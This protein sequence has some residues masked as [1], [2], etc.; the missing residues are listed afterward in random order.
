ML[1][2]LAGPAGTLRRRNENAAH[3][4]TRLK[5]FPGLVPQKLYEGTVSGSFYLY[6]MTYQKEHFNGVDRARSSRRSTP[7][8]S[9]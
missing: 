8:A 6:A 4:T 7:K 5:G 9:A 1:G 3:L 2:Q